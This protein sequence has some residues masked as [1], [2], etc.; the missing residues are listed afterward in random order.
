[1]RPGGT[2][3]SQSANEGVWRRMAKTLGQ[4][5]RPHGLF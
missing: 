2:D 3:D 4:L 1:M 5:N